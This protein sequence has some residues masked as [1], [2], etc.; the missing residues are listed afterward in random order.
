MYFAITERSRQGKLAPQGTQE[1]VETDSE[2]LA[3]SVNAGY[4]LTCLTE[5]RISNPALGCGITAYFPRN[6]SILKRAHTSCLET[7]YKYQEA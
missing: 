7:R 5:E 3:H 2:I 6:K 1:S 4:S